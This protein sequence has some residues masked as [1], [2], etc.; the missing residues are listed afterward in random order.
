MAK[1]EFKIE[2]V[3]VMVPTNFITFAGER[4]HWNEFME[5]VELLKELAE[6]PLDPDKLPLLEEWEQRGVI[7]RY[8]Y[9]Q[10]EFY[11]SD[12]WVTMMKM[13]PRYKEFRSA[14]K[15]FEAERQVELSEMMK[16][17]K[18]GRLQAELAAL[19]ETGPNEGRV[20]A[21]EVS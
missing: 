2:K 17:R 19:D 21:M 1:D 14:V 15:T 3:V 12:S 18:R 5:T 13:G 10:A 16:E 20:A 8:T 11:S 4:Y 6:G 9:K 7:E